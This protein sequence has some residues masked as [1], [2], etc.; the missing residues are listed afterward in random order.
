MKNKNMCTLKEL[1]LQA[2]MLKGKGDLEGVI[3]LA[4]ANGLTV[5]TA[6]RYLMGEEPT[7]T[8]QKELAIGRLLLESVDLD[9]R[10]SV[11]LTGILIMVNKAVREDPKLQEAVISNKRSL[12]GCVGHLLRLQSKAQNELPDE[13]AAVCG[14]T[15]IQDI[16]EWAARE[17]IKEYYLEK[18]STNLAIANTYVDFQDLQ[19]G[20]SHE[21]IQL[22]IS[23]TI[24]YTECRLVE[25]EKERVNRTYSG[26]LES[27]KQRPRSKAR[28]WRRTR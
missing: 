2:A 1:N 18:T 8:T 28:W 26:F 22:Q 11:V 27:I 4:E 9:L 15:A 5:R 7:L 17:A 16:P 19:K 12:L 14:L 3:R 23:D 24:K 6:E 13:I 21:Q 25:A 20:E 10:Q